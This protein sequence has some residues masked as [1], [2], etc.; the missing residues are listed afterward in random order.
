M[1]KVIVSYAQSLDGRIATSSG[2]SQWISGPESL[3]LAHELR[4]DCDAILVGAGTVR[5]DNPQLSC[6]H[7]GGCA[8]QPLRVV[9]TRSLDLP[10]T[11][12][13]F[14]DQTFQKTLVIRA[15]HP[16]KAES[17]S[18]LATFEFFRDQG[19]AWETLRKSPGSITEVLGILDRHGVRTVFV[20]GGASIL[21]AFFKERLVDELWLVSAPMIIGKGTEAIGELGVRHLS[22]AQRGVSCEV[23]Q[24]GQDVLWKIKFS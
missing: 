3:E 14:S 1:A 23:R 22:Q 18:E 6:R 10:H 16:D 19:I 20:E 7:S 9:L 15:G 17:Q 8:D 21:T 2:D 4:R 5:R 24:L 11:A 12:K 13:V